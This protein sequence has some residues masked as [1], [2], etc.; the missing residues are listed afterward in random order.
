MKSGRAD[1]RDSSGDRRRTITEALDRNELQNDYN[2]SSSDAAG[3]QKMDVRKT[4]GPH[5][6]RQFD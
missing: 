2:D 4:S 3:R 5:D 6:Y 1:S